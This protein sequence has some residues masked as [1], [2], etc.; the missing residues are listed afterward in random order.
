M[1]WAAFICL[2]VGIC[3][4]APAVLAGT[5]ATGSDEAAMNATTELCHDSTVDGQFVSWLTGLVQGFLD[6]LSGYL[7]MTACSMNNN[8]MAFGKKQIGAPR[9]SSPALSVRQ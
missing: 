2:M 1:A 5:Q 3:W 7:E 8:T 9:M 4:S 6:R